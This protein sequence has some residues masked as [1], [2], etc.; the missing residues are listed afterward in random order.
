MISFTDR[1]KK[2]VKQSPACKKLPEFSQDRLIIG[3]ARLM[4]EAY[5]KGFRKGTAQPKGATPS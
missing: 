2:Y 1:A 4:S 3:I 5:K